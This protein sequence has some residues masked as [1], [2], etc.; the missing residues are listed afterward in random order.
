MHLLSQ[1]ISMRYFQSFFPQ[2][3][4]YLCSFCSCS[5]STVD[6]YIHCNFLSW[7]WSWWKWIPEN[8]YWWGSGFKWQTPVMPPVM[9]LI[10]RDYYQRIIIN[11]TLCPKPKHP[12]VLKESYWG[13]LLM[14]PFILMRK[15]G[16]IRRIRAAVA[17]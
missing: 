4:N 14:V 17:A 10:Q 13:Q 8:V 6:S 1:T 5:F 16:V 11:F 2:K 3:E 12:H 9:Y 7:V 15:T